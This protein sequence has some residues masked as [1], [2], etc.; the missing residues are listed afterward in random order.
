MSQIAIEWGLKL[1]GAY[2][3]TDQVRWDANLT[4]SRNK[5]KNFTEVLYN[6]GEN[7][8]EFNIEETQFTDTDI[9]FSPNVIGGSQLTYSPLEGFEAALLSKYVGKQFLDNTSNDARSIDAYFVND[10]RLSY[11][12]RLESIKNVNVSLLVNNVMDVEYSSNGYTFGYA[13]GDFEVRENYF[14]PQAGRNFLLAL[15]LRF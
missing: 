6:Y 4:L 12:F 11:D 10:V 9:S 1:V 14:Y 7:F 8:D 2:Q 15:N 3:F 13:G 5:I